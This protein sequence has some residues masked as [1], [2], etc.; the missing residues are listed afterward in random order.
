M[1]LIRHFQGEIRLPICH[2]HAS[3]IHSSYH[4]SSNHSS[5][6]FSCNNTRQ[7]CTNEI[8]TCMRISKAK[9]IFT[10]V[11]FFESAFFIDIIASPNL[12]RRSFYYMCQKKA[13]SCYV[14]IE[15]TIWWK[16]FNIRHQGYKNHGW[17]QNAYISVIHISCPL[18]NCRQW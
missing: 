1:H 7:L 17:Y 6:I 5:W 4:I 14:F 16:T 11:S 8:A 13:H 12:W 10:Q 15:S 2:R 3:D 18:A 9:G